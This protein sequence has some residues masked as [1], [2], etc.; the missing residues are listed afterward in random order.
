MNVSDIKK[1]VSLYLDIDET[2]LDDFLDIFNLFYPILWKYF[3]NDY[4]LLN[5]FIEKINKTNFSYNNWKYQIE[6]NKDIFLEPYLNTFEILNANKIDIKED[7]NKIKIEIDGDFNNFYYLKKLPKK[8]SETDNLEIT[9]EKILRKLVYLIV[10]FYY[11]R[12]WNFD[13]AEYYKNKWI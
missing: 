6:I 2:N 3:E 11:E 12:S 5:F 1:Q 7:W 13:L 9:N 10:S 8:E 4:E